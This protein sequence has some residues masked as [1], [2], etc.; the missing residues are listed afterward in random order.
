M[1]PYNRFP[2][3]DESN[4][5]PTPVRRAI[6]ES[7]EIKS[8]IQSEVGNVPGLID[9]IAQ[10]PT[11]I[12]AAAESVA[13][14]LD[15][16]GALASDTSHGLM[17]SEDKVK[18][19]T[20]GLVDAA[21]L[22]SS[23][24]DFRTGDITVGIASDST[25]DGSTDWV[26]LWEAHM[27]ERYPHLRIEN[28]QWVN[29]QGQYGP[30]TIVQE[31]TGEP[32][33]SGNILKDT[34]SRSSDI[35]TPD[36]GGPWTVRNPENWVLGQGSAYTV[37]GGGDLRFNVQ[38][39]DFNSSVD[40][41]IDTTASSTT[42]SV[43]IYHG[44][45][46]G[47]YIQLSIN[48][49][50]VL[51]AYIYSVSSSVST[52]AHRENISSAL[53]IPAGLTNVPISVSV[54]SSIQ[55]YEVSITYQGVSWDFNWVISEDAYGNSDELFTYYPQT[56]SSK[57]KVTDI[58][59]SVDDRP[60]TYQTLKVLSGTM[61]GGTI[62]YQVD[63]WEDMFGDEIVSPGSPGYTENVV[64]SDTFSRT[65]PLIGSSAD[66]GETWSGTVSS[67]EWILDGSKLQL[68]VPSS[69]FASCSLTGSSAVR[70]NVEHI[71]VVPTNNV[72]FRVGLH[73]RANGVH[74]IYLTLTLNTAGAMTVRPYVR[75]VSGGFREFDLIPY[76][77][78]PDS[79]T[80]V[81]LNLG[82]SR[83]G[84]SVTFKVGSTTRTDSI[85]STEATE[86]GNSVEI[87]HSTL[88]SDTPR[89][90]VLDFQA[91][92][93]STVPPSETIY[94]DPLD[95]MILAHGHNYG[96]RKGPEFVGIVDD[97]IK[98]VKSRR[99]S[100]KV[101]ISSQNPQ[102]APSANPSSHA[103]RLMYLRQYA[104]ANS[105]SYAPVFEHF[106]Q[107]LDDGRSW[108][109]EDG[110]HPTTPPTST[111]TPGTGSSEWGRILADTMTK[112]RD[113]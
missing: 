93:K 17:T 60:S 48:A 67:S 51:N 108:V 26:R 63:N 29:D 36:E 30:T 109:K 86:L 104:Y 3:I 35:A 89:F 18:L 37:G 8:S 1:A 101:L 27:A 43:R 39:R 113:L 77:T 85:T 32:A 78:A 4:Q 112:Y 110:V 94:G 68:S 96:T 31:G 99:P 23:Q 80:P 57:I 6:A 16:N 91:D 53:N 66:S 9:A 72:V 87:Y 12:N 21:E 28:R 13:E 61:G 42:S 65:G 25:S 73:T 44:F 41:N 88:A 40:L 74:G 75:T 62:Q 105:I 24:L 100:T 38:T 97:F 103:N 98:F 90:S 70:A 64:M 92:Y 69:G 22:I 34:F 11:V 79:D 2:A 5:F 10:S 55:N 49:S 81:S 106:N 58:S 84:Q 19:D 7:S 107:Q 59:L 82:V 54:K 56:D 83:S 45:I 20:L 14:Y 52:E 15:E 102:F 33:F 95:V 76:T 46:Y 50:G 111:I 71:T 47:G